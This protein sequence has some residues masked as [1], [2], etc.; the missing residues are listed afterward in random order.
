MNEQDSKQGLGHVIVSLLTKK[1]RRANWNTLW[2]KY[3]KE[4]QQ[5]IS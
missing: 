3:A 2:D 1:T 4:N 5:K